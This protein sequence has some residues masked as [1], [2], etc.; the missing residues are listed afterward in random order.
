LVAGLVVWSHF[1]TA[2]FSN[3]MTATTIQ[4]DWTD[5]STIKEEEFENGYKEESASQSQNPTECGTNDAAELAADGLEHTHAQSGA[6]ETTLYADKSDDGYNPTKQLPDCDRWDTKAEKYSAL[7]SY[8]S[9]NDAH[10]A[11]GTTY[12]DE[13]VHKVNPYTRDRRRRVHALSN[14]LGLS[15]DGTERA[16]ELATVLDPR[17]FNFCGGYGSFILGVIVYAANEQ[18]DIARIDV[19]TLHKE[20]RRRDIDTDQLAT[21]TSKVADSVSSP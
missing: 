6:S 15:E 19:D 18:Q 10:N 16:T 8:N 17:P 1:T 14:T 4:N 21:A 3:T 9:G 13:T 7:W 2:I 12:A 20:R 5:E 11:K